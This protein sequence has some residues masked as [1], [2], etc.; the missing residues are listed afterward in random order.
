MDILLHLGLPSASTPEQTH[1]GQIRRKFATNDND[2]TR[3]IKNLLAGSLQR[4]RS[5]LS[6]R[7]Q[8]EQVVDGWSRAQECSSDGAAC[9]SM[10]H[11]LTRA[12]VQRGVFALSEV[13]LLFL[14]QLRATRDVPKCPYTKYQVPKYPN[15]ISLAQPA[16][17]CP[18]TQARCV[19]EFQNA[20]P[21]A[22]FWAAGKTLGHGLLLFE[23]PG[24]GGLQIRDVFFFD[25][26]EGDRG[27]K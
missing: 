20:S 7:P 23:N 25:T 22:K 21:P 12:G 16:A 17:K 1:V 9:P 3:F 11:S 19:L 2:Q 8:M 24:G 14:P 15:T 27:G 26:A 4:P 13:F 5:W 18:I 6:L 10:K